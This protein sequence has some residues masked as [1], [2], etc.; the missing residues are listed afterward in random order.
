[1][2]LSINVS[3]IWNRCSFRVAAQATKIWPHNINPLVQRVV[4]GQ[5]VDLETQ[6]A[7]RSMTFLE[8]KP[9]FIK[10]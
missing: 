10:K 7:A 3:L 4:S 6:L 5:D 9:A 2:F 8:A 1:M